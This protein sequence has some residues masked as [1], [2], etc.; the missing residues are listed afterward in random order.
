MSQ[1][2]QKQQRPPQLQAET[3]QPVVP[4]H[5]ATASPACTSSPAP[6]TAAAWTQHHAG[7]PS[8]VQ[9]VTAS[10]GSFAQL[11]ADMGRCSPAADAGF[12][13]VAAAA[14][15]NHRARKR[16]TLGTDPSSESATQPEAVARGERLRAVKMLQRR[17]APGVWLR[18][19]VFPVLPAPNQRFV[20]GI[21]ATLESATHRLARTGDLHA[22][23]VLCCA[24]STCSRNH[25]ETALLCLCEAALCKATPP[26]FWYPCFN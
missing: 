22:C 16:L 26:C 8:G 7:L 11:A 25:N 1:H 4:L 2:R 21:L 23:H 17:A 14:G 24:A 15:P 10:A 3:P 18:V 20:N 19:Q 12:P 6:A 5:A 9:P 13:A